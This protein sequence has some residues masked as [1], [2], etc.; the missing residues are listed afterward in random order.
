M[1]LR[2]RSGVRPR[3]PRL[4]ELETAAPRATPHWPPSPLGRLRHPVCMD[5]SEAAERYLRYVADVR[6]LSPATVRAYRSDLTDLADAVG[7]TR[8]Q[9]VDLEMLRNW[10]WRASERGDARSTLARRA[11]AV[12]TFFAWALDA[13]LIDTDPAVRLVAPKR[14]RTL[15]K[16]ASADG[17]TQLLDELGQSAGAGGD[18]VDLRDHAMLELLY[19]AA[20]RVSELC[21]L[22]LTDLDNGRRTARVWGKGAKERVVPY[23]GAAAR[24]LDAYLVRGRPALAVT[25]TARSALFLGVRGARIGSRTVYDVVARRVGALTGGSVGPHALRHSGATHLLDGGADLRSVQEMLGHA[26]LG[27]TQIYT[28]VSSER[29]T[30]SYRLAHPRA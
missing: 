5:I 16:V 26:S 28:H 19:G 18:A 27:T 10:M 4:L 6:R 14:G 11:A 2:T 12:R 15:P 20:L 9:D 29:L 22:D 3:I 23:G 30:A 21:A 13:N 7:P 17:L 24:A 1:G 8:V 25:D